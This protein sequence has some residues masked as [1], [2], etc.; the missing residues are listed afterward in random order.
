MTASL[1]AVTHAARA[2]S[3][4]L[5]LACLGGC[6][7]LLPQATALSDH[8]PENLPPSAELKDVPFFAQRDYQCGPAA[9]AM[10]LRTEHVPVTTE[11]LIPQV[12]LPERQGSLQ[13]EMLAAPRRYGLVS[14]ELAPRFDDV[15]RE[16][17]G[18][19]PVIVLQDYGAWPVKIW[20][21]AV[22]VGYDRASGEMVLHS[23]EKEH[24]RMPFPVFE[25]LWKKSDYWAMLVVPPGRV[26]VTADEQRYLDAVVAMERI[27]KPD[28]VQSAYAGALQR[29]PDNLTAR[30]GLA[31]SHYA[32]GEL[33][34]A[35]RQ[36]RDA[37]RRHPD[38][39]VVLNNLAQTLSD[40]GRQDE[41]LA[42]TDRALELKSPFAAT[43]RETRD[44]ILQRMKDAPARVSR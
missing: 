15:L 5:V 7:L 21:Y 2:L 27:A 4:L 33:D 19:T 34:Q 18:G 30:I 28:A 32:Q 35:E 11:D 24:L 38:S 29:W 25:Y 36:L 44:L 17:A 37:E 1:R 12:Y 3:A 6:A 40:E 23:G 14:Y 31:N 26:P 22:V 39:V 41:A 8:W 9:L 42:L 13:V 16:V 10:T 20:H 43:I